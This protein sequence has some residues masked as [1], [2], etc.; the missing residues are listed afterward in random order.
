MTPAKTDQPRPF[1]SRFRFLPYT[2]LGILIFYCNST[3][4]VNFFVKGYLTILELQTAIILLYFLMGRLSKSQNL[5][6]DL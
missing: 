4:D 5:N 2:V 1:W 6:K 3:W